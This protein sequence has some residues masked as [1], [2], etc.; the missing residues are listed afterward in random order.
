MMKKNILFFAAIICAFVLGACSAQTSEE[1]P[2][3]QTPEESFANYD[4]ECTQEQLGAQ[5]CT[6][7][8]MPVCGNDGLT[9]GNGCSACASEGVY[10]YNYGECEGQGDRETPTFDED[11]CGALALQDY[12]G[13]SIEEMDVAEYS[14]SY[15]I[16]RPGDAVTMDYR[17]ERLNVNLNDMDVIESIS[18][19]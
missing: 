8:Y 17:V 1:T 7:E 16:I 10:A 4:H 12:V 19:G 5:A 6:R 3:P 2:S 14:D 18:C 15:R 11:A 9:Y 13:L